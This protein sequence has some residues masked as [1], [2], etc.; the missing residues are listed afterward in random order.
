MT[1]AVLGSSR[2]P[3]SRRTVQESKISRSCSLEMAI[4]EN[5]TSS[6]MLV[7]FSMPPS[8]ASIIQSLVLV[9]PFMT[10]SCTRI[11]TSSDDNRRDRV[12]T[13]KRCSRSLDAAD[14]GIL[15]F[16]C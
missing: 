2:G 1:L 7:A 8:S 12:S 5:C 16:G 13:L 15:R 4:C 6:C 11:G 10:T 9:L 3:A 14:W